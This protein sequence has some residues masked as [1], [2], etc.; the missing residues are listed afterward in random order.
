MLH[1]RYCI[2]MA[3][4]E[5]S[6]EKKQKYPMSIRLSGILNKDAFDKLAS[7]LQ[8]TKRDFVVQLDCSI[9]L[10]DDDYE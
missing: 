2:R 3:E 5:S 1:I 7:F 10:K 6:V 4:V 8:A 9:A